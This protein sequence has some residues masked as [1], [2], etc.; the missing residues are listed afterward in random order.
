[1]S[2][3]PATET[4]RWSIAASV[5][6][7]IL[8][9]STSAPLIRWAA[10][11]PPLLVA[12]G[13]VCLAALLLS[14]LAGRSLAQIAR[15]PRRELALCALSGLLLAAHFGLW[16]TSLYYTST[17]A[18]VALVAT[19][20]IF[21]GLLAWLFLGE[22]ITRRELAG[23]AVAAVGCLVLAGG[24]LGGARPGALAGDALA[25]GGALTAGGYFVVGRHMRVALPL[26]AYLAA[27]N[28]VA[29]AVLA[30]A[31]LVAGAPVRGFATS[32]YVAIAACAVIP[33]MVGHS[34]LNWTVRRVPVHLVSLAGLGEPVGASL[35]TWLIFAEAP[36]AAAVAGGLII[37]A[38]IALGFVRR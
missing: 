8:A 19:Q 33:S 20:P 15:V 32:D 10:P 25:L 2:R 14:C 27:V 23:I 35:L 7:G 18:S 34:L 21:G 37:L 36:P 12:A 16:I 22:G 38:G 1:M 24:D 17:A 28:I 30:A 29:G 11:A 5:A 4:I 26:G 13:R 31:L 9:V 6:L 3:A